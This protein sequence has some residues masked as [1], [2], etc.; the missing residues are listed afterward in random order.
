MELSNDHKKDDETEEMISEAMGMPPEQRE[1][2]LKEIDQHVRFRKEQQTRQ[3]ILHEKNHRRKFTE[4]VFLVSRFNLNSS[5]LYSV[6]RFEYRPLFGVHGRKFSGRPSSFRG[7]CLRAV[8][9]QN[10]R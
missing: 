9:Q 5:F 4:D 7:H 10:S 2:R 1:R 3:K 8:F 6:R